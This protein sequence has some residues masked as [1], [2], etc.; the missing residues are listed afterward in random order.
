VPERRVKHRANTAQAGGAA[1]SKVGAE[2][3]CA[4]LNFSSEGACVAFA[5]GTEVPRLFAL[6]I[7]RE[8]TMQAVRVVWRRTNTVGLAFIAPRVAPDVLPG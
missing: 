8:P 1:F 4:V 7:G 6:R 5:P 3:P 2:V